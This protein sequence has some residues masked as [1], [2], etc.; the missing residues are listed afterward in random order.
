MSELTERDLPTGIESLEANTTIGIFDSGVGGLSVARAIM[1]QRPNDNII[2]IADHELS[3]YGDKTS[4]QIRAR[5]LQIAEFLRPHCHAIVIACNTATAAGIDALRAQHNI[6]IYGLEPAI[7]PA[8]QQSKTGVVGVLATAQTL[9]SPTFSLLVK[10]YQH[11]SKIITQACPDFIPMVEAGDILSPYPTVDAQTDNPKVV[12]TNNKKSPDP[13]VITPQ[14]VIDLCQRY[15]QP[16][17]EAR[18]DQI[19]LGCSHYVFLKPALELVCK[20][21]ANIINTAEALAKHIGKA[22]LLQPQPELSELD[23]SFPNGTQRPQ[24]KFYSTA[25]NEQRERTM[26]GLWPEAIE[27]VKL[28]L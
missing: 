1:E 26:N 5:S 22:N 21:Q 13:A 9:K 20:D 16:L 7:K 4:S 6:P 24:H 28:E 23:S 8:V 2:Y 18:A 15:V 3:P 17:L 12:N 14:N 10:R 27:I 25:L 11:Q 19:V